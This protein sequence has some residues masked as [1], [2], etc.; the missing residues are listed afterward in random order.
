[1]PDDE[2]Y[3][4][5]AVRYGRRDARKSEVYLNYGVYA[6]PDMPVAMDYYFWV[7]RGAGRVVLLDCGFA[8][9]AGWR[10]GRTL[11]IDPL[12]AL[13]LLG[14]APP[15]V[16]HVLVSH[17]HYDHVGNLSRFPEASVVMS[18]REFDFW[19]GPL[20][21][22]AQFATSAEPAE[23]EYL[24]RLDARGGISF[25]SGSTEILPGIRLVEV[26]GHT[27][28][29]L[30]GLVRTASGQAVL[31]SDALHYYEELERDRPFAIVSD[32][33]AMYRGF[34]TLAEL[35]AVPDRVLVAGHDPDVL[36]RFPG[37]DGA[38]GV[39]VRIG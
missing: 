20:A 19:T 37:V 26:G 23:L 28:G 31:A 8:P 24:R 32:L 9:D 22:R 14:V 27:P 1:V 15:E 4:V 11:L 25:V 17:A 21:G 16:S 34:D 33:G 39:A 29:Q 35:A 10:R 36:A 7:A 38:H 30:I 2:R 12:D 3:E 5:Y 18:R 6:E 13:A